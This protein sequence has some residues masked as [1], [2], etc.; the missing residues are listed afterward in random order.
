MVSILCNLPRPSV[1]ETQMSVLK[2]VEFAAK[3]H[4]LQRRKDNETPYINHTIGVAY[5]L[6]QANV[7]DV[8]VLQA[9]LLHDTIEDT[10]TTYEELVSIFG[11]KVAD[12]V[13]SVS[14]DTSLTSDER[15]LAQVE[16]MK[17]ASVETRAIK[18]A[19][20]IYNLRDMKLWSK[21]KQ[22]RYKY[23]G[24]ELLKVCSNTNPILEEW[25]KKECVDQ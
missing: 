24:K 2:A 3:K 10:D 14:D 16:K 8:S 22:D 13:Q 5:L 19:D 21:E 6:E 4:C 12:L 20:R 9:A 7:N 17:T 15:K 23:W 1:C 11:I 18:L 25:L